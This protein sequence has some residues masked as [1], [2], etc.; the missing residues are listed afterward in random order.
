MLVFIIPLKSKRISKSWKAVSGLFE[1]CVKS[2]CNQTTNKFR[3]IVVC[4]EKPNIEFEH[5]HITY[6]EHDF[7]LPGSDY[8]SKELDRT[9]KILTGLIYARN[10]NPSHIMCVDADDCVSKHLAEFVSCNP[11][12]CGWLIKKG[13]IYSDGSRLIRIMR[14]GFDRYCGTSNIVK[15]DLYDIPQYLEDVDYEQ[16]TNIIYNYYNH[17]EIAYTLSKKGLI[18]ET[19]PFIGA[20]YYVNHGENIYY[21]V[22]NKNGKIP[23]KVKFL[24]VKSLF[25]YRWLTNSLRDD[26]GL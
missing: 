25:D 15:Y 14:K 7:S 26:F 9:R 2:I 13:Y 4:N 11:H 20:V 23:L 24:R 12:S 3:V 16:Y 1:R 17:R 18:I 19:L 22:E 8:K 10:F 6:I 5:P 21:G